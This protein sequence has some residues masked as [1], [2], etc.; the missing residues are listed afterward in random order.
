MQKNVPK[1]RK[2]DIFVID[3]ISAEGHEQKGIR[4]HVV[5]TQVTE[6]TVSV[7]PCTTSSKI[8]KY[9]VLLLPDE[10][11]HLFK[12]SYVLIAQAFAVDLSFLTEKIGHL[13]E[14]DIFRIQIEYIKYI[15]D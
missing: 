13:D 12:K 2:G 1:I 3:N 11:N 8:K 5:V 4:P 14:T 10:Q 9:S 7:A 6:G 15:T